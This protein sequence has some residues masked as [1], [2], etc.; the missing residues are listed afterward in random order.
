MFYPL[1]L[2]LTG[3]VI[4]SSHHNDPGPGLTSC[5]VN[6]PLASCPPAFTKGFPPHQKRWVSH[7]VEIWLFDITFEQN[8]KEG[9]EKWQF[10]SNS[11]S[12]F[13]EFWWALPMKSCKKRIPMVICLPKTRLNYCT[14]IFT[15]CSS[16]SSPNQMFPGQCQVEDPGSKCDP[17][18]IAHL[19]ACF[20]QCCLGNGIVFCLFYNERK[21]LILIWFSQKCTICSCPFQLLSCCST[22]VRKFSLPACTR[23]SGDTVMAPGGCERKA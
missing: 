14:W 23:P 9:L 1:N 10:H 22:T 16:L 2:R 4:T 11:R 7:S 12:C 20:C 18:Q 8:K 5:T 17:V 15:N 13:S 19:H 6:S 3:V 21:G